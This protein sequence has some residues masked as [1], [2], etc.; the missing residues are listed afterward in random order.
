MKSLFSLLLILFISGSANAQQS[1]LD[2]LQSQLKQSGKET[3]ARVLALGEL[4]DYYGFIQIDSCLFYAAQAL[5]LAKKLN[6][7]Y[8]INLG[9]MST[10]H[11]LN[12]QGNYSEALQALINLQHI[13]ERLIKDTPWIECRP[14]YLRGVLFSEMGEDSNAIDQF[15]RSINV[16]EKVKPV[17]DTY[18]LLH[19]LQSC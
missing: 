9:Y 5:A 13:D 18:C 16:M 19:D 3:N 1:F 15:R 7:L 10:F 14:Y 2:T 8:G 12:C 11:G 6:F 4:A 17:Y